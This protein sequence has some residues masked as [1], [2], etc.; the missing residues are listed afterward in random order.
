[1]AY[2][3]FKG[4]L[5]ILFQ[6][7]TNKRRIINIKMKVFI[8]GSDGMLGNYVKSYISH[9]MSSQ[10]RV[11][12]LTRSDYDLST[13]SVESLESL[14]IDNKNMNEGDIVI[15]CA[16]VIP[17]A[18][19]QRDLN[20]RLYFVI[21]SI[22]PIILSMICDKYNC[23]MIHITTDCVFSG[24]DGNYDENSIPDETNDYGISKSLG[25]LSK[26]T[27]IRTSIIG[28]EIKNKRSLLEWVKSN[29]N[30]EINGYINHMW[31]GITCLELAKII[32]H[33]IENNMYWTGIRHIFSPRSVSKYELVSM[34]NEIYELDITVKKFNTKT[35]INKTLSTIHNQMFDIPDLQEQIKE[36]KI[37]DYV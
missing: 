8:F 20:A 32:Y 12:P 17:Q 35:E 18:S 37:S 11:I 3:Q 19:N 33:I 15:N 30:K 23:K 29:S 36:L 9:H 6:L 14:L 31:N 26:A 1:L 2:F 34:I 27:I 5:D 13:L 7:K 25:D 28:E 24:K 4:F 16:G 22:F 10:Y 21:N